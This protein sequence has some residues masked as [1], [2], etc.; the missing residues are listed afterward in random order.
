MHYADI[1]KSLAPCGLDCSRCA[2]YEHGEIKRL[3]S[4]LGQLLE[5][6]GRVAK[7]RS[8]V[9][10]EF[11]NYAHFEEILASF[12]QAP[13]GGCRSDNARCPIPCTAR[14]C[15]KE[16]G[17]DFCFQCGEYPCE[18]PTF[19]PLKGRWKQRNDRMKE[20]GALDFFREQSRI[21][22]Y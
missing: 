15:H 21:P 14:T 8:E 12:S 10:P 19:A 6:F 9:E 13:C 2:G 16:K 11:D 1:L 20:I 4:R 22:R 5:N 17:V 7:L 3:S 18:N